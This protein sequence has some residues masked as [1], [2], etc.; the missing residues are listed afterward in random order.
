MS[1]REK[2]WVRTFKAEHAHAAGVIAQR[3]G[4]KTPHA[5]SLE[6][7]VKLGSRFRPSVLDF[8]AVLAD[9][10]DFF[11]QHRPPQ[12]VIEGR[13]IGGIGIDLRQPG[14]RGQFVPPVLLESDSCALV[15]DHGLR[16]IDDGLQD[17]V[18]V[19]GGGNFLAHPNQRFEHF[20]LALR[21]QQA[22]VMKRDGGGL[23]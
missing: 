11:R 22:R 12:D 8:V 15:R 7:G 16:R 5:G 20:H 17:A 21:Q 19:E 3:E 1:R 2:V 10:Y 13:D 14:D 6:V 18:Q 9:V 4:V 23:V